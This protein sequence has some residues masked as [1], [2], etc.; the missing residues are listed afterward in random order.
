MSRT[1]PLFQSATDSTK[2]SALAPRGT[3]H[4]T[5]LSQS[6]AAED[7]A[8]RSN[9]CCNRQRQWLL[10]VQILVKAYGADAVRFYFMAELEF[11]KDG[12]FSELRFQEKV[13]MVAC[14]LPEVSHSQA[15]PKP[16]QSDVYPNH[17]DI[18]WYKWC[19][20]LYT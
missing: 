18:Y 11:G 5:L 12:D 16:L 9:C 7:A 3:G 15:Y 4:G 14:T 20:R 8:A 10:R 17:T 13:R 19:A 2:A 1:S 6:T